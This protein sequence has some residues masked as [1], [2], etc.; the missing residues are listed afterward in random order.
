M[1]DSIKLIA[2]VSAKTALKWIFIISFGVI[3]TLITFFIALWSN[4]ELAGGGHGSVIALF[5][6]LL[7][8]NFFAFLLVFGSPVFIGLYFVIAN[9][10]SIQNAIYLIW[11]GKAGDYISSKVSSLAERVTAKEGWRSNLADK[12]KLKTKLLQEIKEEK[13]TSKLQRKII[14]YG[15]KKVRL[16]DVDFKDENL[17]FSDVLT[18]K[19]NHFISETAKPSLKLFWILVIIQI[20]LLICSKII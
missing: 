7:T 8:S 12:A 15:F 20:S 10:I 13:E 1:K 11:K 14:S 5:I 19:F 3:L 4:A 6:G 16:D 9:K 17:K 2:K 18:T